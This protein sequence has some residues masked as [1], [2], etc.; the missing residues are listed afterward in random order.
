M[1]LEIVKYGDP[2]LRRIAR[3]LTLKEIRSDE[4]KQLVIDLRDLMRNG[5]GVGLAAPQVGRG[6]QIIVT[7]VRDEQLEQ[8]P[9]EMRAKKG[10]VPIPFQALF[11]PCYE[12]HD[13]TELYYP[14]GC[15][16]YPGFMGPVPRAKTVYVRALNEHGL[17]VKFFATDWHARVIQHEI[18]HLYGIL[19]TDSVPAGMLLPVEEA[20]TKYGNL[21]SDEIVALIP[22]K[23]SEARASSV[24]PTLQTGSSPNAAS[25]DPEG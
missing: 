21:T 14:E 10:M 9:I 4:I 6:I 3:K 16:S 22:P 1:A 25:M 23:S 20:R 18:D 17:E 11:N 19:Y 7:E 8:I 13:R 24:P 12:I 2:G 15:L 5:N